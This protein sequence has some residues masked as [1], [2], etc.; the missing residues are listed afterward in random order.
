MPATELP[1]SALQSILFLRQLPGQD[2]GKFIVK[3]PQVIHRHRIN[4]ID[5]HFGALPCCSSEQ[6]LFE[7]IFG[8]GLSLR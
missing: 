3:R 5:F 6:E 4:F 8:D 1:K 2:G 7:R